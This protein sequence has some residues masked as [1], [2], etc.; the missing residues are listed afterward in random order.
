V[1]HGHFAKNFAAEQALGTSTTIALEASTTLAIPRST[2][3]YTALH[4]HMD[5]LSLK[6]EGGGT[7]PHESQHR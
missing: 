7:R 2:K 4:T 1:L 5:A 6:P 3:E